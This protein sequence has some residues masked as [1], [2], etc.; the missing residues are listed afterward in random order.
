MKS[1]PNAIHRSAM[2]PTVLQK[3]LVSVLE[4]RSNRFILLG[5][6]TTIFILFLTLQ[7]YEGAISI[8]QYSQISPSER[9][10]I[11]T[12]TL[13]D[14]S[15]FA[16]V[17]SGFFIFATALIGGLNVTLGFEYLKRHKKILI[18]DSFQSGASMFAI[19]VGL[20]CNACG[21]AIIMFVLSMFGV[22]PAF[23]GY[24]SLLGYAGLILLLVGSISLLNSLNSHVC[25]QDFKD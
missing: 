16:T 22:A 3:S 8:F 9:L 4:S 13:F 7:N 20:G 12:L 17:G 18:R 1:I 2:S 5:A 6:T 14:T 25:V 11:G 23:I 24:A 19:F 21:G 15:S 10:L